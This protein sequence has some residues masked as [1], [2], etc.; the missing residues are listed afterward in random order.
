M[1]TGELAP[2]ATPTGKVALRSAMAVPLIVE[3]QLRGVLSV[4][5]R[6]AA[7]YDGQQLELLTTIAQQA[8]VAIENAR[9]YQLATVD[10]LTGFHTRDH[11]FNRLEHEH[12]R[13]RRYGGSFAL[14]MLD[15]DGFK[16]IN[17][18]SGHLAGDHFLR[19]ITRTVRAEL[20]EAD[21]P[22]RYGGDEFCL[23]LPETELEGA[24]AIAERIREAVR[25]KAV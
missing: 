16:E 14:L 24:R 18:G 1:E 7:A 4:A 12:R 15:L 25:K 9:H 5:C 13:A 17:D 2:S 11:F 20:R 6:R 23:L 19:V 8:A 22:C 10:S 3:Q 21:L